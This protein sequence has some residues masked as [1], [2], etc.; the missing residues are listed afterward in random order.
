MTGKPVAVVCASPSPSG[1]AGAQ[2]ELRKVLARAG[3][4]VFNG[5]LSVG[6][7]HEAFGPDAALRDPELVRGLSTLLGD[8]Q[9]ALNPIH[10]AV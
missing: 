2:A 7:A 6:H 8:L 9:R 10:E 4:R 1:A 5:E 3:T